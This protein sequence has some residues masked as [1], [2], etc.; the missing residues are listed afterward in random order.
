MKKLFKT[1][2]IILGLPALFLILSGLSGCQQTV[3]EEKPTAD[4][5]DIFP[6]EQTACIYKDG[7]CCQGEQGI[8]QT[9]QVNCE[10]GKEPVIKGCDEKCEAIFE[11]VASGT[12]TADETANWLTYTNKTAS[13]FGIQGFEFKY[14]SGWQIIEGEDKGGSSEIIL[15]NPKSEAP[16]IPGTTMIIGWGLNY[17]GSTLD[18]LLQGMTVG[19]SSSV[20]EKVGYVTIADLQ[21]AQLNYKEPNPANNSGVWEYIFTNAN[22]D[23][24]DAWTF[25]I[26]PMPEL[27]QDILNNILASFKLN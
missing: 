4:D 7:S 26:S 16:G 3:I 25:S 17:G 2:T 18:E 27:S 13:G 1:T 12:E 20:V 22:G 6:K 8:C 10:E 19:Q 9:V 21:A 14:P 23:G 11:C 15:K 5:S 24:Q